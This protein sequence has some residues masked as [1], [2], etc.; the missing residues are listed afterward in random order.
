MRTNLQS[1]NHRAVRMHAPGACTRV[2]PSWVRQAPVRPNVGAEEGGGE[3]PD[4]TALA[5]SHSLTRYLITFA[6]TG[7]C[8]TL[9]P[10]L[11]VTCVK[12]A[13]RT[14]QT[15]TVLALTVPTRTVLALTVLDR[16]VL[17]LTVLG[18]SQPGQ[19]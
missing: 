8:L 11:T 5:Y 19:S 4:S 9:T 13:T 16:T 18:Q 1:Q 17:A 12:L 7:T 2:I 10:V 15:R 3:A 6:L 14:V